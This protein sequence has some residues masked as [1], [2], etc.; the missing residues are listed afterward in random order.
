M[1]KWI[2]YKSMFYKVGRNMLAAK[3]FNNE[4]L[5]EGSGTSTVKA[6]GRVREQELEG[7]LK[8]M[9]LRDFL[10]EDNMMKSKNEKDD[11]CRIF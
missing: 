3:V 11:L 7:R 4:I 8:L 10:G 5:L 9:N 2:Q 6:M 1:K